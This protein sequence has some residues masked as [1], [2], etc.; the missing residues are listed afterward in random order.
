MTPSS[1][2][3]RV[4]I[5]VAFEII[6][7]IV[8]TIVDPP[9]SRIFKSVD[10]SLRRHC[11][12]EKY[13]HSFWVA[14]IVYKEVWMMFGLVLT[15]L[16]KPI[17]KEQSEPKEIALAI[18]NVFAVSVIGIP[19]AFALKNIP[20]ALVVVQVGAVLLAFTFTLLAIFF[21][22]W[23]RIF[24]PPDYSANSHSNT[25]PPA[26]PNTTTSTLENSD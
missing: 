1:I 9:V 8:W 2:I 14:F 17:Q 22:A 4:G 6:F 10:G 15:L 23:Y 19:L 25:T 18:Y 13:E 3:S 7:L 11:T 16:T 24:E 5:C 20:E 26:N 21:N 12:S